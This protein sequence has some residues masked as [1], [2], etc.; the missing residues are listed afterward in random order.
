MNNKEAKKNV[1]VLITLTNEWLLRN[2]YK[3]PEFTIV[4]ADALKKYIQILSEYHTN[5]REHVVRLQYEQP[6]VDVNN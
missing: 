2:G 5:L 4:G 6:N 3:E 1:D